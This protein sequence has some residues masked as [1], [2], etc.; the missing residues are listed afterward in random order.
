MKF[1]NNQKMFEGNFPSPR[2]GHSMMTWGP[3]V[4]I[5]GGMDNSIGVYNDLHL[6]DTRCHIGMVGESAYGLTICENPLKPM[7]W[8]KLMPALHPDKGG[9]VN[10]VRL[11]T[12]RNILHDSLMP[13]PLI[14]TSPFH[15]SFPSPT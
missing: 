15:H 1:F 14:L 4:L 6:L 7:V 13:L 8:R 11:E 5:F 2:S 12:E 9:H 10:G 3:N